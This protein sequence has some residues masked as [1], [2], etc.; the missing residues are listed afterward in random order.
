MTQTDYTFQLASLSTNF[1]T[2]GRTN[3][4]LNAHRQAIPGGNTCGSLPQEV[5]PRG[6]GYSR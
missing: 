2:P 1:K 5:G 6:S 3:F 4:G